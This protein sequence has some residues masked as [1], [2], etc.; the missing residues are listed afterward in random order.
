[1]SGGG[2]MPAVIGWGFLS[3]ELRGGTR[4]FNFLLPRLG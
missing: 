1:M 3:N 2:C 4:A